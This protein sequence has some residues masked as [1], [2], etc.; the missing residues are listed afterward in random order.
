MY[1]HVST[2]DGRT[3]G[4]TRPKFQLLHSTH[5]IAMVQALV[6]SLERA[7]V[8]RARTLS[9]VQEAAAFFNTH[10]KDVA[11]SVP[12]KSGEQCAKRI[13]VLL[14]KDL[15]RYSMAKRVESLAKERGIEYPGTDFEGVTP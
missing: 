10:V 14:R 6:A 8:N 7:A 5:L 3:G 2:T 4:K 11:E 15:T 13:G 9:A 12:G 1:T